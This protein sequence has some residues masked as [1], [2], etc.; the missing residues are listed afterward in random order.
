MKTKTIPVWYIPH[1]INGF[2]HVSA[3]PSYETAVAHAEYLKRHGRRIVGKIT[4]PHYQEVE[5]ES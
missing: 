4:G 2:A 1:S 3:R 5:A